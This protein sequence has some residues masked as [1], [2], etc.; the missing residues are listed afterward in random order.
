MKQGQGSGESGQGSGAFDI[1]VVLPVCGSD[2]GVGALLIAVKRLGQS[3][4]A[5][6]EVVLVDD[7]SAQGYEAQVARWRA[8]F[9]G[10]VVARHESPKG[11][12]AA[13]RTGVLAARGEYL[14][15]L[16]PTLELP[17]SEAE[18]L[19]EALRR[20]ADVALVSRHA[21]GAPPP[22]ARSFVERATQTT[23]LRLSE[24]MVP[25]G[26]ADCFSG[27]LAVRARSAKKVAQ[28]SRV[29]SVAWPVEWFALS[30][31]LGFQV[32]ELPA[33]TLRGPLLGQRA[34]RGP[35]PF[36]LLKDVWAT[37]RRLAADEYS[38]SLHQKE[39][40]SDT[41]FRKLDRAAL[42]QLR[43]GR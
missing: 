17:V 15:L 2:G 12:G 41:S 19:F 4:G 20:G 23:I 10:L 28:R 35:S 13:V 39:L 37:R 14:L 25:L 27:L 11:R 22:E 29:S 34:R 26:I 42:N 38:S 40:L 43:N 3:L 1:S 18:P 31:Y 8:Q 6:L 32:I 21:N 36:A 16:D 33:R 5:R 24:M 9:D 7:G 30:H